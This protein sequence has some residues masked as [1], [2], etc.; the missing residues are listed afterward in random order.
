M[1]ELEFSVLEMRGGANRAIFNYSMKEEAYIKEE[2]LR[3][4]TSSLFFTFFV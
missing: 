4:L 1:F 3:N 2:T